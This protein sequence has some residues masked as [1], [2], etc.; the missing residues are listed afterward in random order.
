ML[1]WWLMLSSRAGPWQD[2]PMRRI[3]AFSALLAGLAACSEGRAA[4]RPSDG[5]L[6]LE[7]GGVD[8]SLR[9]TLQA[10]GLE[11]AAP[12]LLRPQPP[13]EPEPADGPGAD[14][15]GAEPVPAGGVEPEPPA[16]PTPSA[17][18][19]HVVVTLGPKQTLTHLAKKHLGDG[20]RYPEIMKLNGWTE[21][22]IL[23]LQPGQKVK[24]PR[25]TGRR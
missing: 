24:I 3:L 4:A 25:P 20:T 8:S 2:V 10:A 5:A 9:R 13:A 16:P 12:E 19:D 17:D 21:R 18:P 6:V 7:L 11:L 14:Q 23:R 1:R 15:R 22:D